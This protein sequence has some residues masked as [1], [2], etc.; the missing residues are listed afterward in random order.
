LLQKPH[1]LVAKL[2][3]RPILTNRYVRCRYGKTTCWTYGLLP[4]R[5]YAAAFF[6][7]ITA[8][9]VDGRFEE[10]SATADP[11]PGVIYALQMAGGLEDVTT[12]AS[13]AND[14]SAALNCESAADQE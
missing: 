4:L 14:E 11:R 6:R 8:L 9:S 13:N 10:F 7:A 1:A 12:D 2:A 3:R 5:A